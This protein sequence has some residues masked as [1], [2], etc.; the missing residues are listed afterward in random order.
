MRWHSLCPSTAC[1][2]V[3]LAMAI[4][5]GTITS[6]HA[7]GGGAR[8]TD[9]GQIERRLQQMRPS[10]P[11]APAPSVPAPTVA[12]EVETVPEISFV[13]AGVLIEGA[14]VFPVAEFGPL[15]VEFL[16]QTVGRAELEEIAARVTQTYTEAGYYISRAMVPPQTVESGILRVRVIEGFLARV[17]FQGADKLGDLL[18]SYAGAITEERPARLSTVERGLLLINGLP[19]VQVS[20]VQVA[21]LDDGGAYELA[22]EVS[23]DMAEGAAYLDNRGTPEVGRLQASLSGA[24]NS[25]AGLG[26]Q[27]QFA[28]ATVPD[29]PQELVYG[30]FAYEQPLGHAGT[31]LGASVA[32]SAID[33]GAALAR[34]DTNGRGLSISVYARYPLILSRRRAVYLR[35]ALEYQDVKEDRFGQLTI[36]DSLRVLRLQAD[37]SALDSWGGTSFLT[38]EASQGFDILNASD[39][40]DPALSR[41]DGEGVF[42][43]FKLDLIRV[44]EIYGPV[45]LRLAAQGQIALA[46]LLSSEEFLLGG[47]QFGRA[48]DFGEISGEDGV[49]GSLELRY[50]R[51]REGTVLTDYEV[52]GFYDV[53]AVWNRNTGR[54]SLASAGGG[55]RLGLLRR[56]QASVEVTKPLTR[57]VAS[58]GDQDWRVFFS[59]GARF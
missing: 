34:E 31:I 50:S 36:D 11:T 17:R 44:Q 52:Y 51:E 48:Y 19:G 16:A 59:L 25:V 2:G 21:R 24:V 30:R 6:A 18:D 1:I 12:P 37:Y 28:F 39:A 38:L 54:D 5:S 3:A 46:P 43:K 22:V 42:T 53:G 33:S 56:I 47:S 7:Q 8:G 40:S 14:T 13:L 20:D 32:V 15:Y 23:Y 4:G 10:V 29:D 45:S 9:P 41:V 55:I 57:A 26:E 35:A 58:T 27:L 49:A